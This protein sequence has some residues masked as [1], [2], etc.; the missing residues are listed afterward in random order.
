MGA[1][2]LKVL[3][4]KTLPK[5]DEHPTPSR[6]LEIAGNRRAQKWTMK[7]Q[8]GR[9]LWGMA[10]PVFAWSP[11]QLWGWR[12]VL[13]RCFGADVGA[14]AHIYPSVWITIPWNL[15][16]GEEAAV[17]DRVTLYALGP[18]RIGRQVT[19]SQ[20]AHICAGTHDHKRPDMP[21]IKAP[22]S[23]GDGAWICA[24]AFIGPGVRI[25]EGAIVGARGVVMRDV[26]A[27]AVVVGNPARV[28][29]RRGR[30]KNT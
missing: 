8:L 25:S 4:A 27:E 9:I 16:I 13:L 14:R 10:H 24:D 29:G 5:S 15:T 11:R 1:T 2:G 30:D 21:L 17:G 3:R 6:R 28:V 18:I 23:I 19:I 26:P 7:E 22:I 20:G 12:R